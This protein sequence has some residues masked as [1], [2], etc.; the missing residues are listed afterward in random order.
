M[1]QAALTPRYQASVEVPA[2]M[3][4]MKRHVEPLDTLS[5]TRGASREGDEQACASQV[6]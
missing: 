3:L 6:Q 5:M 1:A 4:A 2:V